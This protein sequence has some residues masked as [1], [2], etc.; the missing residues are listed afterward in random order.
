MKELFKDQAAACLHG[1]PAFCEVACPFSLDVR[2]FVAKLQRG[3]F[4]AAYRTFRGAAVFPEIVLSYCPRYCGEA[5]IRSGIDDA[6]DL[7]LLE[8]ASKKYARRLDPIDFNLPARTERVAVIGGGVS[9]LS[10]ALRLANKKFQVTLFE[11]SGRIGGHLWDLDPSGSFLEDIETQFKKEKYELVLGSDIQ[12]LDDLDFDAF[13]IATGAGGGLSEFAER[14]NV[15]LGGALTGSDTMFSMADGAG[16]ASEIDLF[17]RAGRRQNTVRRD[18]TG[19]VFD[20]ET[21]ELAP[22]VAPADGGAYTK[23][24]AVAE[25]ER[26]LKCDCDRCQMHCDLMGFYKKLPKELNDEVAG[27]ISPASTFS[28]RMSTRMLACENPF[29]LGQSIC[30][31]GIDFETFLHESHRTMQ[32]QGDMPNAFTAYWLDDMSHA[33]GE[34]SALRVLPPKGGEAKYIYFP[35]CQMG[36]SRP[37]HVTKSYELLLSIEPDTAL[38]LGCC[39]APALWAAKDD[40]L[41]QALDGLRDA[42]E[43]YGRPTFIFACPTCKKLAARY[44]VEIPSTDIY[45]FLLDGG[46]S[47]ASVGGDVFSVFDPCSSRGDEKMQSAVRALAQKAGLRLEP[48]EY[49]GNRATCCSFGGQSAIANPLFAETTVQKRA[50]LSPNPYITYCSNCS[51]TFAAKGKEN[52]H[53]LDIICGG[54]AESSEIPTLTGR[55]RNREELRAAIMEKYQGDRPAAKPRDGEITLEIS[56]ELS[57]KLSANWIIEDDIVKTI[58]RCEQSGRKILNQ[59]TGRFHGHHVIGYTTYWVEYEK[60]GDSYT[61][62][63]A[64]SHRMKIRE[65]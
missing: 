55:R 22:K 41:E 56:A 32:E 50:A 31:A 9:G 3:S 7:H 12:S 51:D 54:G 38:L 35:G 21:I 25:A 23:E 44:A 57:A 34:D 64:Y 40:P 43:E 26:C 29:A 15:F 19:L 6:I 37:E 11:K 58:E 4:D 13:Y 33:N 49:E 46:V 17:F 24:E 2:D 60:D 27:T 5:C 28:T 42:W 39:G 47:P 53:I 1:E 52:T 16:A 65:D 48:L 8:A 62:I 63:N 59:E 14:E 61:L 20:P 45:S 30:P 18:K 36:A 10:C